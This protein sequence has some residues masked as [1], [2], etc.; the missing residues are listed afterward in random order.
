[1]L[2]QVRRRVAERRRANATRPG[3]MA[4]RNLVCDAGCR[5]RIFPGA[6]GSNAI[7]EVVMAAHARVSTRKS[8][9]GDHQDRTSAAH[10]VGHNLIT[11][12]VRRRLSADVTHAPYGP[13]C[14]R[15]RIDR[16]EKAL[17]RRRPRRHRRCACPRGGS[18][19]GR[20]A[21]RRQWGRRRPRSPCGC[22]GRRRLRRWPAGR[23]TYSARS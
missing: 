4:G 5:Y 18:G 15:K 8:L 6:N 13:A 22:S 10:I 7:S 9:V 20:A 21:D 11:M 14:L 23:P 3:Y 16:R 19:N 12:A 17:T 1:M 2:P